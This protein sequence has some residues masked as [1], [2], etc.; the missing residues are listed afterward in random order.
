M[1]INNKK[2][3]GMT[4]I[5][6]VMLLGMIAFFT[7]IALKLTPLYLEHFEVSSVLK[8][9]AQEPGIASKSAAEIEDIIMK[10]LGINDVTHVTKDNIEIS[11]EDGKISIVISYEARVPMLANIDIVANFKDDKVEVAA[12]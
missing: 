10:R 1:I 2:Q 5:G 6:F 4:A 9:L 11:K 3:Q 7:A 12:H 8:S